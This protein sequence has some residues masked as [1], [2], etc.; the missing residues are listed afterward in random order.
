MRRYYLG[1]PDL[2]TDVSVWMGDTTRMPARMHSQYLRGVFLENRISAGRFAVEG[3]VIALK[4]IAVP[5]FVIAT[6]AD[7]IAPWRSVYKTALFTD[8]DMH[9]LLTKGGHNGG[10]LSEPG[11]PRRHYRIG[12][13]P[14]GAF[15]H[16]PDTWLAAHDPVPGSWW[17]EWARWL[18]RHGSGPVPAPDPGSVPGYPALEDAPGSYVHQT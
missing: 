9:F 11:H 4:D 16:D 12:H 3:R 10:I 7:H 18:E 6:E 14:A 15:Y 2:P 1:E 5:I 17:P 13:R 8:C